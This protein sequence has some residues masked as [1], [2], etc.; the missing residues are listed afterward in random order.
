MAARQGELLPVPYYHV[1][2]TLPEAINQLALYKP[3]IVYSLLFST[4]WSTIQTFA[5]DPK[6]LGAQ[7]GMISILHTWG[8]TLTLHH[9][10]H[11]ILPGGGISSTG[12]WKSTPV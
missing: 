1:V 9:H 6:Y 3:A 4:A 5:T 8:Q 2:F 7:T 11:C 10:L 12:G